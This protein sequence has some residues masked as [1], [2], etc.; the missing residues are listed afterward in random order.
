VK[1][2]A[3][4]MTFLFCAGTAQAQMTG[5]LITRQPAQTDVD[6]KYAARKM[7]RGFT[8]CMVDR[9]PQRIKVYLALPVDSE[10]SAKMVRRLFD[11]EG[12]SCMG[13][14]EMSVSR[15][16]LRGGLFEA[17]YL[18]DFSG[19]AVP[20]F[21]DLPSVDYMAPYGDQ[22][23]DTARQAVGIV[24]FADCVVRARGNEVRS[25]MYLVPGSSSEASNFNEL[26][27]VFGACLPN[28]VQFQF[29]KSVLRAALAEAIYRLTETSVA[30]ASK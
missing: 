6:D 1:G 25:L 20:N 27:P 2:L 24:Q 19:K 30:F 5:T 22:L 15:D 7:N 4:S 28:D 9:S 14:A 16:L 26:T 29:S 13:M 8:S 23:S 11:Q 21:K 17:L 3:L 12:D 18:R 10:A